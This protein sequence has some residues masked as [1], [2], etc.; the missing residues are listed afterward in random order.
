MVT[1]PIFVINKSLHFVG[2]PLE[3]HT[4]H[5]AAKDPDIYSDMFLISDVY[6]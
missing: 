5:N 6:I 3:N 2:S 4:D 1:G